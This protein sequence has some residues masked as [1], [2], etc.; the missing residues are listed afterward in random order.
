M[1]FLYLGHLSE[2]RKAVQWYSHGGM[3]PAQSPSVSP[4]VAKDALRTAIAVTSIAR[5]KLDAMLERFDAAMAEASAMDRTGMDDAAMRAHAA[6]IAHE[7]T[8]DGYDM[9]PIG[10][11]VPDDAEAL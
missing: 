10:I 11:I 4:H 2:M 8:G 9:D 6:N 5:D 7:V 3:K 1:I